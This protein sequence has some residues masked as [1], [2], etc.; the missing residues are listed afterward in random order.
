MEKF[1]KRRLN[2]I[3]M[4]GGGANSAVWCQI[5]ADVFDRTIR[6]MKDPIMANV[7][8]AAFLAAIALGYLVVDDI[9]AHVE[10]ARVFKPNPKNRRI[11]D[12][13]FQEFLNVYQSNKK[14]YERLN[15]I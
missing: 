15:R 11:Y 2:E 3:N 6:Q 8:G 4:I 1:I 9:P 5:H 7:K 13:L 12:E 14:I 10:T